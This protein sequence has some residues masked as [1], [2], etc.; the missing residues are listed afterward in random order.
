MQPTQEKDFTLGEVVLAVSL[1]LAQGSWKAALHDGRRDKAAVHTVSHEQAAGRLAET[2]TVIEETRT[3]W[4]LP[5]DAR[6][7]VVYEAGQDGF[8]IERALSALGYEV[9]VIDPARIPV[10]RHA[11][12]ARPHAGGAGTGGGGGSAAAP[13]A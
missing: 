7:V 6:V 5:A 13:G 10:E 1:E 8:W 3:K 12:R 9:L 2:V 11:R 4:R